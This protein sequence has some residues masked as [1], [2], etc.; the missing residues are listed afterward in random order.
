[1]PHFGSVTVV[2]E[3]MG[4]LWYHAL[5]SRI[6]RR[7]SQGYTFQLSYTW[8]KTM[9]ATTFLNAFDPVP[10]GSLSADDRTHRLVMSAIY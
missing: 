9:E 7:F 3:P 5:Q 1:M 4:Y 10:Y 8:S 2:S 6:E